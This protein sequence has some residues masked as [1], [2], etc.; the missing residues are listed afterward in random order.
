V[1]SVDTQNA[2]VLADGSTIHDISEIA[3]G[4]SLA[5]SLDGHSVSGAAVSISNGSQVVGA[6]VADDAGSW[7]F[8][9]PSARVE[10]HYDI[11][12]TGPGSTDTSHTSLY[13]GS[14]HGDTITGTSANDIIVSG[15]GNDMLQGGG[16]SDVFVFNPR[17]GKDTIA[18][19]TSGDVLAFDKSIVSSAAD[20]FKH[21]SQVG[22]D[23]LIA[24]GTDAV[25]LKNVQ[26]ANLHNENFHFI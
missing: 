14:T 24:L 10:K 8:D 11:S 17:F 6:T 18:D 1:P 26:V 12:I 13:V 25:V 16:G 22:A 21:A 9:L 23:T 15:P 5:V 20:V 4:K 2:A 7:N 3:R 19:F